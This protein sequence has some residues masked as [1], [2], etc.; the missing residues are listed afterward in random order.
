MPSDDALASILLRLNSANRLSPQARQALEDHLQPARHPENTIAGVQGDAVDGL[1]FVTSGWAA[2]YQLLTDGSRQITAFLIDGDLCN[3]EGVLF[4]VARENL[5]ALTPVQTATIR[6]SELRP[7]LDRH[8][9]L[10]DALWKVCLADQ[11]ITSAWLL[12][13]GA[14]E[15]ES[16]IA[17]LLFEL[18]LRSR[19]IGRS[20]DHSCNLPLTQQEIAD[21]QGLSSVHVN[22]VLRSLRHKGLI[23]LEGHRLQL[24][25]PEVLQDLADF[26]PAYLQRR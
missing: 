23:K 21:S 20:F 9:D 26:D 15:A 22:R 3:P 10:R 1:T 8:R 12:N 19:L 5:V 16:R 18:Y 11:F 4:R 17:H 24:T 2:R 25:D 6:R 13:V 14:R 7:L